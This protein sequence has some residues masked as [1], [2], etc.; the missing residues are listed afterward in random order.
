MLD[1]KHEIFIKNNGNFIANGHNSEI[2]QDDAGHDWILFHGYDTSKIE[3]ERMVLLERVY[4]DSEGWPYIL[5]N[6]PSKKAEA[7]FFKK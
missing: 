3:E 7:P 1:N 4:W 5:E 2:I 6:S